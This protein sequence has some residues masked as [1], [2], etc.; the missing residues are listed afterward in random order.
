ML[1][2]SGH[3]GMTL[4][5]ILQITPYYPPHNSGVGDYAWRLNENWKKKG[6]PTGILVYHE[7]ADFSEQPSDEIRCFSKGDGSSACLL[8]HLKALDGPTHVILHYVG[9][10]YSKR[11]VPFWLLKTIRTW[12][13]IKGF[14]STF[15]VMFHE[16][17]ASGSFF[18]SSVFWLSQVQKILVQKML[19]CADRAVTN[20]L[21]YAEKLRSWS[22]EVPLEIVG[23]FSTAGEPVVR[24]EKNPS[25]AVL[26]GSTRGRQR[27]RDGMIQFKEQLQKLGVKKIL[28]IGDELDVPDGLGVEIMPLGYLTADEVSKV[29]ATA[30]YGLLAYPRELLGKS[31][32]FACYLSHGCLPVNIYKEKLDVICESEEECDRRYSSRSI[33]ASSTV[34]LNGMSRCKRQYR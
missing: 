9:Y 10:G 3:S 11:G 13:K 19:K 29:C 1:Y 6:Y 22:P 20:T 16:L 30:K 32:V 31:T 34:F 12:S 25:A 15:Q 24:S 8:S 18:F 23:V 33:E 27:V 2:S 26:F 5:R 4:P 17:H 28:D 21:P 7:H 14:S